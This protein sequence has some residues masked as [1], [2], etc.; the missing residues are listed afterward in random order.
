M[1]TPHLNIYVYINLYDPIVVP[2][3]LQVLADSLDLSY[4]PSS[5]HKILLVLEGA[6]EMSL[7]FVILPDIS[8]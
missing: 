6:T 1:C 4:L 8:H 3:T 7:P 5:L 2:E